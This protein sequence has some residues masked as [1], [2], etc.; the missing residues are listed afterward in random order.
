VFALAK[1][2]PMTPKSQTVL[3]IDRA[4]MWSSLIVYFVVWLA[5][6]TLNLDRH[7]W[8]AGLGVSSLYVIMLVIEIKVRH[9]CYLSADSTALPVTAAVFFLGWAISGASKVMLLSFVIR[10]MVAWLG[11]HILAL[12]YSAL[13]CGIGGLCFRRQIKEERARNQ[14]LSS[15][16]SA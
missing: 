11:A 2:R 3:A 7:W 10:G 4:A 5:A 15:A 8:P 16:A 12:F 13:F 1:Y 14:A 6:L 9:H